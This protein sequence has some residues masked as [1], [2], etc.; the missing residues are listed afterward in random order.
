[1]KTGGFVCVEKT[2]AFVWEMQ[3]SQNVETH[4]FLFL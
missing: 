4:L 1:V 3:N 2:L